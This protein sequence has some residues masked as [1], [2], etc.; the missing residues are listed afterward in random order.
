MCEYCGCDSGAEV[1][2]TNLQTGRLV[3]LHHHSHGHAHATGE[4]DHS[5]HHH[6]HH[7]SHEMELKTRVLAKNDAL[8]ASNRAWLAERRAVSLNLMSGPGS[9]KTTLL[10]RTIRDL[11]SDAGLYVLEGDQATSN[12]A[13]RVRRAGADVVQVNTGTGCH[14]DAHMV[15]HGLA[16]LDPPPGSIIFIENVGNLVCPALFDLGERRRVAILSTTEGEDKPVKYPHMFREA[17][18]VIFNKIDLMPHL[19]F[20]LARAVENTRMVNPESPILFL[21]ARTGQ[22]LEAWYDWI[23]NEVALVHAARSAQP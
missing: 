11:R 2:A 16:E 22:G 19:D 8:A 15:A 6:Q 12:D 17:D 23:R 5:H 10:E 20:D 9:G 3:T 14:L 21:S 7:A 18:L 13:E 1:T 4:A